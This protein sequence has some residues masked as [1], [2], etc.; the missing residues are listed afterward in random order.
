MLLRS[1]L[2]VQCVH[3]FLGRDI[4]YLHTLMPNPHLTPNLKPKCQSGGMWEVK[5]KNLTPVLP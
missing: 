2:S 1:I 4:E 3:I 5:Y